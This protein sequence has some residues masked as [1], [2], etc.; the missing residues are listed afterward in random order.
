MALSWAAYYFTR[1]FDVVVAD[2]ARKA[3]DRTRQDVDSLLNAVLNLDLS[4]TLRGT[5]KVTSDLDEALLRADFVQE[6]ASGT[7][8]SKVNLLAEI[9]KCTRPDSVIASD[10]DSSSMNVAKGIL[11]F[12]DRCI[13]SR[14]FDLPHLTP[15]TVILNSAG[16][17]PLAIRQAIKFY[18]RAGRLPIYLRGLVSEDITRGLMAL[19][20]EEAAR[21]R[22]LEI[23]GERDLHDFGSW[24]P[25]LCCSALVSAIQADNSSVRTTLHKGR[26]SSVGPS[27]ERSS[28]HY[29]TISTTAVYA[30]PACVP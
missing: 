24:A 13:I 29:G 20:R 3:T 16:T 2:P 14:S 18:S 22:E 15:F 7:A 28:P 25:T 30:S 23:I 8:S 6:C 17:S 12:G 21:L 27:D 5:L 1:G 19:F 11:R 4:W 10:A 26:A 9:D